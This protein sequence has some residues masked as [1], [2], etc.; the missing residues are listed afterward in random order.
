MNQL[1]S[2]SDLGA[3]T[4]SLI[5][6]TKAYGP[7]GNATASSSGISST[8]SNLCDSSASTCPDSLV[9][10]TLA[11]FQSACSA[12]LNGRN[13]DVVRTYD[14][15]YTLSPLRN[16]ICSKDETGSWCL[17]KAASTLSASSKAVVDLASQKSSSTSK[18]DSVAPY[19][20]VQLQKRDESGAMYPNTTTFCKNNLAFAFLKPSLSNDTLCST[21]TRNILSA[22]ITFEMSVPYA[23]GL[24]QSQ[25]LCGQ[26]DLIDGIKNTC[27]TTFLSSAGGV[28]AA[29]SLSG[30]LGGTSAGFQLSANI[31]GIL[32]AIGAVA[33]AFL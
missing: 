25:I 29:G 4:S 22:Y 5:S 26:S 18:S 7:G 3:C 24:G 11:S 20:A 9:R 33:V 1:D 31:N 28:Q 8:L 13:N 15:F 30:N 14:I 16:A 21:C 32:A 12:E 23:P 17:T 10:T 6:A 2:N 27:G 19:L